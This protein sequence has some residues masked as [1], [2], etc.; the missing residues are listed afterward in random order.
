[1]VPQRHLPEHILQGIARHALEPDEHAADCP[2]CRA[3]ID[4]LTSFNEALVQEESHPLTN[5]GRL[6]ARL[7]ADPSVIRLTHGHIPSGDD[8][9]PETSPALLAAQAARRHSRV[10]TVAVFTAP[11]HRI[12]LRVLSDARRRTVSLHLLA[13]AEGLVRGVNVGIM[14]AAGHIIRVRTD[15]AGVGRME[16]GESIDWTSA[17]VFLFRPSHDIAR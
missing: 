17:S 5:A 16:E 15:A 4:F 11:E 13:D 6:R 2:V 7:I 14:N 10:A 12:V 1:M 8:P 9:I 3:R